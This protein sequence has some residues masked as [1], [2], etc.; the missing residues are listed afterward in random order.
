MRTELHDCPTTR[1]RS[2]EEFRKR[3]YDTERFFDRFAGGKFAQ[4]LFAATTTRDTRKYTKESAHHLVEEAQL[5]I[6]A[7]HA[8]DGR[9][10][11][12]GASGVVA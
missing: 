9:I 7:V 1:R 5:F 3:F 6:E 4:F 8:C 11:E 2:C 12:Q 10:L